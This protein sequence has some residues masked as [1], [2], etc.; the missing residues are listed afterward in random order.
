MLTSKGTRE[1]EKIA[2]KKIYAVLKNLLNWQL[3]MDMP[4]QEEDFVMKKGMN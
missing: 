4:M 3:S 1:E 2:S